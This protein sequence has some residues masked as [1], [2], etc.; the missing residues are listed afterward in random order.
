MERQEFIQKIIELYPDTFKEDRV[1]HVQAWV[2]I[3]EKALPKSWDF[4]KLMWYFSTEY[5]STV[6]PPHPSFFYSYRNS[7]KPEEKP[8]V[9]RERPLTPEEQEANDKAIKEFFQKCRKITRKMSLP[10]DKS[11]EDGRLKNEGEM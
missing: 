5:K 7:V 8:V 3:Y 2:E 6:V 11:E 1:Q 10:K 4:D 9:I